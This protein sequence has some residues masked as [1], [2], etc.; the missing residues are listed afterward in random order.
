[1]SAALT[2]DVRVRYAECDPMNLAHHAVYPVWFEMARTELLRA[3]GLAYRDLEA[4]G[5]YFVVARLSLRYRKPARYDDVLAVTARLASGGRVKI[6]H[7]YEVRRHGLLL[8]TGQSTLVCV[9]AAGRPR[10]VPEALVDEAG[11]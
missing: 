6:E 10:E 9:N 3:Q 4:S 2:L 7:A 5:T 1:M 8:C 11:H